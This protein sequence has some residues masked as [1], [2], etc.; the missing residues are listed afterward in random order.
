[1]RLV[2]FGY[3]TIVGLSVCWMFWSSGELTVGLALG[4][5]AVSIAVGFGFAAFLGDYLE[6][7]YGLLKDR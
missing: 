5:L 6:K 7:R 1:M 4:I 3:G 2:G